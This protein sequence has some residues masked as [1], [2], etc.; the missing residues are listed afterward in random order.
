MA[1][2]RSEIEASLDRKGFKR[3]AGDHRFFTYSSISG[4]KTSVWMK[5]SHGSGYKTLGDK[6]VS[7]MSKQCG[8]TSGQFKQL[9]ACPLSREAYEEILVQSGRIKLK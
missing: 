1:L 2:D 9:V 3:S 5:T 7:D 4:L 6:L 8:L